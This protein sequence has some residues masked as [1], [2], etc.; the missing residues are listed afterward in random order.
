MT[1]LSDI[2]EGLV[3]IDLWFTGSQQVKVWAVED[4]ERAGHPEHS[5]LF[6]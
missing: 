4:E 3:T 2:V 6:L 5:V 1:K